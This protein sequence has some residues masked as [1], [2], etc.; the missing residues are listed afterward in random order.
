VVL[1]AGTWAWK[2]QSSK[3]CV[4]TYLPN[5][6]A[7]KINV[8]QAD[9]LDDSVVANDQL[10]RVGGRVG[11]VEG[12]AVKRPEGANSADLRGSSSYIGETPMG[13]RGKRF[14]CECDMQRVSRS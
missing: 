9:H 3:K 10:R 5:R 14:R 8:A 11:P 13:R 6:N 12:V 2:L 1:T 7:P 4:T